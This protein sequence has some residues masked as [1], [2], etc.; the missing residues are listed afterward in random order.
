MMTQT[1]AGEDYPKHS[2]NCKHQE[3]QPLIQETLEMVGNVVEV[4]EV[5][6]V[7]YQVNHV[8]SCHADKCGHHG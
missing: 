5:V 8:G 7:Y 3:G 6:E 2:E 4:V 1:Y